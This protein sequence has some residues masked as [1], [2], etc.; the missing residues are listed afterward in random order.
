MDPSNDPLQQLRDIHVPDPI[1]F[2]PPALGWWVVMLIV[3]VL[4][5]L[6]LWFL[7]YRKKTAPRRSALSEL[8]VLKAKFDETQDSANLM[9]S[10]S[11]LLRRYAIVSFGRHNVAGLAGM[12]WL[13]FLD[14]QGKTQQ[15]S[16][17]MGQQAF[18]GVPYGSKSSVN[19]REMLALTEQWI[20]QIP[21]SSR[22]PLS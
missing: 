12:S 6:G 5:S 4:A 2:W 21:L 15:F 1:S 10:L 3:L 20:K 16:S 22:N 9:E 7:R 14:E 19:A 18:A 17:E 8:T 13:R 11:Q